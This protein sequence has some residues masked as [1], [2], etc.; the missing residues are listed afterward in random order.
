MLHKALL[1]I[2]SLIGFTTC[3]SK[4]SNIQHE[5][6]TGISAKYWDEIYATDIYGIGY[7][8]I[9]K[10]GNPTHCNKFETSGKVTHYSYLDSLSISESDCGSDLVVNPDR[11]NFE[12][13]STLHFGGRTY[14]VYVL[15]KDI[16][17]LKFGSS[18]NRIATVIYKA[19]KLQS[20]KL[21]KCN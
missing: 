10:L 11:F 4:P 15:S 13:D 7:S 6:L 5:N 14:N 21:V 8:P 3:N 2:S 20:K 18:K 16:M 9:D 17:V 1:V 12:S 19:S